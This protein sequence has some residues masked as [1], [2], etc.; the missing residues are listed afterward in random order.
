M[1]RFL[2]LLRLWMLAALIFGALS[3]Q[4]EILSGTGFV[5]PDV[6]LVERNAQYPQGRWR[7]SSL[8]SLIAGHPEWITLFDSRTAPASTP[9]AMLEAVDCL[10][11]DA[12]RC[13][14]FFKNA[15]GQM[16]LREFE[17]AS[18]SYVAQGFSL[19]FAPLAAIWYDDDHLL[20]ATDTG[21]ATLTNIGQP[22]ILRLWARGTKV[23]DAR[24]ILVGFADD[25]AMHAFFSLSP[26][27]LFHAIARTRG[28][29][30]Q[31]LFH[32]GWAQNLVRAPLPPDAQFLGFFQGRGLARVQNSWLAG[33]NFHAGGSLVAWPMAP[34]LGP[35]RRMT[36][37]NAYTPPTGAHIDHVVSARDTLFVV[38]QKTNGWQLLGLRKGAPAW[39]VQ[40]LQESATP[41]RLVAGSDMADLALLERDGQLWLIGAGKAPRLVPLDD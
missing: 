5:G 3:A 26:G 9:K 2:L 20:I 1:P 28:D 17:T 8:R 22:R 32:L 4:A 23:E 30:T 27:G 12:L 18:R 13:L 21:P 24:A 19:P 38:V 33:Q 16:A 6:H 34:L 40:S 39:R 29:G 14:L 11:P 31:E 15:K 37:E 25:R 10:P 36:T 41:V 7:S 35:D